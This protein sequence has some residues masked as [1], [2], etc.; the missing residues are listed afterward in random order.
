MGDLV[1]IQG[2]YGRGVNNPGDDTYIF[3]AGQQYWQTIDDSGG[4]DTIVYQGAG[5]A[6]IN[7]NIG[8]WSDLG[9][10][11]KFADSSTKWTVAIGPDTVIE[12]AFGG[13][14]K[15]KLIGNDVANVLGGGKGKD[16]LIGGGGA[17]TFLF[18]A[19]LKKA[20]LSKVKD[21]E[22]G[23]DVIHI[24]QKF[25]KAL[26]TGVVDAAAFAEHFDYRKG[27]LFYDD[28]LFARFKGKP[29]VDADD[30]WIV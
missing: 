18:G 10:S 11:I 23:L 5:K 24:K 12:N 3:K 2:M 17:D 21:F 19:A 25:V 13:R 7:L 15:D 1:A 27:K 30:I 16:I 20:N 9:K 26:D 14:G 22:A 6:I 28:K 8:K 29:A 4:T